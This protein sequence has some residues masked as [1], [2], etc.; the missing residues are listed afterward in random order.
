MFNEQRT[1]IYDVIQ[2]TAR[3]TGPVLTVK[4]TTNTFICFYNSFQVFRNNLSFH[5]FL[6]DAV[7]VQHVR[8]TIPLEL[9]LRVANV[10][11]EGVLGRDRLVELA[12][13]TTRV[14]VG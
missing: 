3:N 12:I 9:E 6:R 7:F 1:D 13:M 8:V 11:E 4:A 5:H 2:S 10:T 14:T